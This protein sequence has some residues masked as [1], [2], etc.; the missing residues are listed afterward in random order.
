MNYNI[1]SSSI[2][3]LINFIFQ[4]LGKYNLNNNL[5]LSNPLGTIIA[6]LFSTILKNI[7]PENFIPLN[8]IPLPS[9][10]INLILKYSNILIFQ[11][12]FYIIL[13]NDF[14]FITP[15]YFLKAIIYIIIYIILNKIEIPTKNKYKKIFNDLLKSIIVIII[16]ELLYK[17]KLENS[18]FLLMIKIIIAFIIYIALIKSKIIKTI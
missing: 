4:N 15:Y 5:W 7:I 13:Y 6:L 10:L 2:V 8:L 16:I 12:I 17:N 14:S 9:N 18:N 11:N 1:F 3:L